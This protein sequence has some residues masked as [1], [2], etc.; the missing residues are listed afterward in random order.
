M[1]RNIAYIW[2]VGVV[3]I[4]YTIY[5]CNRF[6]SAQISAEEIPDT[7]S[8]NFNIR[9]ILSD[10]CFKCHG[11]DA[12]KRQAGLRLDIPESAYSALKDNP[13]AHA[14][15]PGNLDK[16]ELYQRVSTT[17]TAQQMPPVNSNLKRLN[18][19]ELALIK[20]WI[21]QG[22][23][24]EKHWAFVPPKSTPVPGVTDKAWPKSP[25]DNFILAKL[26]K[27]NLKPNAEADKER[28]LKRISF[29]LNG[30]PPDLATMDKFMADNSPNAYEKMVDELMARPQ[31]GEK[32][33][34]HWMDIARYAD[35]HG[36]QDDNYRTQW[37]WRDWVIHAYNENMSYKTFITWQLAGDLMPDHT[38]EQ[39]LATGF[40]RN[41]KI[42]EEG[43]VIDE[44]YR[45]SYVTDRTNTFGKAML[46]VSLEC[47]HCHD[48][49]YDPFSQKEYYQVFAFFNSV[50]EVGIESTVGGPETY[51]KKPLMQISNDDVKNVLKFI[52]KK[53]TG[54]LIVSVM[55]DDTAY[56]KTYILKRGSYDAHGDSVMPSTPKAILPFNSNYPQNRLGLAKWLFDKE[57]PLTARVYVNQ[58]WQEFFGRGIV[59]TLGD[60]G[61]QG[62]LPSNPQLLDW[63][64]IDFRDHGWNV[65]RLVKQIVMS[66]TYRQ[67]AV[68]SPEKLKADPE[69]I[70]LARGPRS[71]LPAEFVRDE[72]LASSGLLTKTIG[73][74]SV[75]PYQ[76]PGLWENA[77][78]GRG[79][80]ASYKQVHGPDLYR[81]GMYTLIKRTVP[82]VEM[83]IFDASN[84]DQCEVQRL[85]T[86]T[87]LQ[88]LLMMNDPTVLE[89]ARVL[90]T[91]LLQEKSASNEKI[92]KAFRL[93]ICRKPTDKEMA[94]LTSYYD[95]Q[96]K[97]TSKQSAD[98]L[99]NVGEYPIATDVN[100]QTL[101]AMMKVVD[102]IYNLEEAI[103]KT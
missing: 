56:R 46:G 54:K 66:A 94:I 90:A 80:L 65:K 24:Y 7:I 2:L 55:G 61:M 14:L 97:S 53:D 9:P 74:P 93:I 10:K 47:A 95:D 40:N 34:L 28:L 92:Y 62:D 12:G 30:L 79:L 22:A 36:Y 57:N 75:N 33:A 1:K 98:K 96:L 78:S 100:K 3:C 4:V 48:H 64:A 50:K 27:Y 58:L 29:D 42:T 70:W 89:A 18:E 83:A 25:I 103:T 39:L 26:E 5:S 37:P 19:Y 32:M 82:P 102:T 101:A 69:N 87:P 73:G 60:F 23:K 20:K 43:G 45:V 86:N 91:K 77:T 85:R 72:V 15:V 41:H 51:A 67:S 17:D 68:V 99:I 16:S 21:K 8:Y 44:E 11:P 84:R 63:L 31:Y 38:K 35:S 59:K 49:K 88:A 71:R 81:R 13:T 76:P 6:S 52:N